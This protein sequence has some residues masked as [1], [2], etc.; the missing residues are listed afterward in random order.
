[1]DEA[2]SIYCIRIQPE[3]ATEEWKTIVTVIYA[4]QVAVSSNLVHFENFWYFL[5]RFEISDMECICWF[6]RRKNNVIVGK[7]MFRSN[8][9]VP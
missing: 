6:L 7:L 4:L 2:V 5:W 1:M 3:T 8:L 9:F